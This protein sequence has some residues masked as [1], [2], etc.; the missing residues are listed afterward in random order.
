M[1]KGQ[2]CGP[3]ILVVPFL[4]LFSCLFCDTV[5]CKDSEGQ[6]VQWCRTSSFQRYH[7]FHVYPVVLVS[8]VLYI[9]VPISSLCNVFQTVQT[10]VVQCNLY[11]RIIPCGFDQVI[12]HVPAPLRSDKLVSSQTWM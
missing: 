11:Q 8:D 3:V 10:L 12:A 7:N 1:C 9:F 6:Q 5:I 2:H 4:G